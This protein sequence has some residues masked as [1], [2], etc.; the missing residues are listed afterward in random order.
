MTRCHARITTTSGATVQC[1]SL[2]G[3]AGHHASGTIVWASLAQRCGH[4]WCGETC[5][6]PQRVV[7]PVTRALT[8]FRCKHDRPIVTCLGCD[9]EAEA[10]LTRV[11]AERDRA[12]NAAKRLRGFARACFADLTF[13]EPILEALTGVLCDTAWLDEERA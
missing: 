4:H 13:S 1:V 5:V 12:R 8:G 9:A 10:D 7:M 2:W 11:M 3:H 6:D